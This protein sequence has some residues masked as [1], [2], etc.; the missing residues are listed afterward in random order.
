MQV[1]DTQCLYPVTLT[2]TLLF[3]CIYTCTKI[4]TGIKMVKIQN[5]QNPEL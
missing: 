5:F 1:D 3:T 2:I 4:L